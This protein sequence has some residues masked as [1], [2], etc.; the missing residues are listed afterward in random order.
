MVEDFVEKYHQTGKKLDYLV[1]RMSSQSYRQKELVKIRRNWMM[2]DP[3][4]QSQIVSVKSSSRRR[5]R[6]S[7]LPKKKFKKDIKKEK[8]ALKREDTMNA[9]K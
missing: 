2:C 8:K 7:F 1:A 4:I 6:S 5:R 3:G 9:I